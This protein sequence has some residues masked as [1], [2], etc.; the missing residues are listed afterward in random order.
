MKLTL[1]TLVY[2]GR[3]F[4]AFMPLPT[5]DKGRTFLSA[6]NMER[7]CAAGD[8]PPRMSGTVSVW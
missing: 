3:V 8:I 7:M 5:I 1:V 4:S 2:D 6:E